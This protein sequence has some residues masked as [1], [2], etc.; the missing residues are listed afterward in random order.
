MPAVAP[1]DARPADPP[2]LV[3]SNVGSLHVP[4]IPLDD[5]S[6]TNA[7]VDGIGGSG[8]KSIAATASCT[9]KSAAG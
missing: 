1:Q 5:A 6:V 3:R 8:V 4:S 2:R 9:V 7:H